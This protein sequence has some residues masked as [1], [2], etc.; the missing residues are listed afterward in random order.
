[1]SA[2]RPDRGYPQSW[3]DWSCPT[4]GESSQQP[5]RTR[6]GE[7]KVLPHLR[8][9]LLAAAAWVV[10]RATA[11]AAADDRLR[12]A[13]SLLEGGPVTG[14]SA[15]LSGRRAARRAGRGGGRTSLDLA[16]SRRTDIDRFAGLAA[17]QR[18]LADYVE[19]MIG[20]ET[21][22]IRARLREDAEMLTRAWS[23]AELLDA[24][25][26]PD[27][28]RSG[29][30]ASWPLT[31]E[32]V[33]ELVE[34]QDLLQVLPVVRRRR[35]HAELLAPPR[36]ADRPLW[37]VTYARENGVFEAVRAG[38]AEDEPAGTRAGGGRRRGEPGRLI[39][40]G[41]VPAVVEDVLRQCSVPAGGPVRIRWVS[42]E[43]ARPPGMPRRQA[44]VWEQP[45]MPR[46]LEERA[47]AIAGS[48]QRMAE[49]AAALDRLRADLDP[50]DVVTHLVQAGRRAQAEQPPTPPIEL[51]AAGRECVVPD[52]RAARAVGWEWVDPAA[53][54]NAGS[55]PWGE[56]GRHRPEQM[57]RITRR[58]LTE[59]DPMSAAVETFAEEPMQLDR[60][61][62]PAGPIYEVGSNGLH[63]THLGRLLP[64]PWVF[65]DIRLIPLPTRVQPFWKH[66]DELIGLWRGLL[67]RGLVTG[68]L[69]TEPVVRL[70]LDWAAASWLLTTAKTACAIN[71]AYERVYPG[72]WEAIGV[73]A[74]T[75]TD[76]QRW[77][78]WLTTTP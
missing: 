58:L 55:R 8:R 16:G 13:R 68:Q 12:L 2:A 7:D 67:G 60:V 31:P 27:L 56:F 4:C 11:G 49:M 50:A 45:D 25:D 44:T 42:D 18:E 71:Q 74:G 37:Q 64:L 38:T 62:G 26:L 29:E 61:Q 76:P 1:M 77:T 5:C 23:A 53:I 28:L 14:R 17:V 48:P 39:G 73:P 57:E 70:E 9:L 10:V 35:R 34:V 19:V 33:L 32:Q 20:L 66:Q 65:A 3:E 72:A 52:E 59:Q 30:R 51:G 15:R 54:V 6:A 69:T 46:E 36:A 41:D 43:H 47:R 63:R 24:G 78:A 22:Q 75:A 21:H 40:V